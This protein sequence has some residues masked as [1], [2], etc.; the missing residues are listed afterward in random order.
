[1]PHYSEAKLG[2]PAKLSYE[3]IADIALATGINKVTIKGLAEALNIDRTTL[4]RYVKNKDDVLL[5]AVS[6]AL[7]ELDLRYQGDDWQECLR[8]VATQL[9][10]LFAQYPGLA[11]VCRSMNQA[12][13]ASINA[14][15]IACRQLDSF[16]FST[17]SSALIINSIIDMTTDCASSWQELAKA[18]GAGMSSLEHRYHTWEQMSD[19]ENSP[20]V[21]YVMNAM[22]GD[23]TLW[24]DQKLDLLIA[25]ASVYREKS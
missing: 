15:A 6:R 23:L 2:R 12:P 24:W 10:N 16:G 17:E 11:N 22:A 9:W 25:G 3:E 7:N 5:L 13:E 19:I 18:K 8:F 4:Y 20:H 14:F 21:S 1:M